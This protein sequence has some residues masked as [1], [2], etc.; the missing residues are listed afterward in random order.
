MKNCDAAHTNSIARIRV[1]IKY[2]NLG[3]NL[4]SLSLYHFVWIKCEKM[5]QGSGDR[6]EGR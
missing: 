6:R 1:T 2:L 3:C 4:S 5:W